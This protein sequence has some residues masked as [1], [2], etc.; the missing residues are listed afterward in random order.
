MKSLPSS[1]PSAFGPAHARTYAEGPARQV[2]GLDGLHRMTGQ[3][4]AERVPAGGRVLV[5]GAGGGLELEALAQ[6]HPGWR[7]DGVDPSAAML[8]GARQRTTAFADRITLHH[9]YVEAAPGGPF[10]GA[11]CL[12]T[13]HFVAAAQRCP[14][15]QQLHRRLARGAP[16]VVA[17]LSIPD[18]APG[19]WL[20]RHLRFGGTDEAQL[21]A[22]RQTMLD[23][24]SILSP[25]RDE[26]LLGEAG[27][28]DV[29]LFYAGLSLRGWVAYA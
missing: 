28:G 9:G 14:T 3:L 22:A 15:L 29:S 21:P 27:F 5:L 24:L 8:E 17:H 25:A 10:D 4:L 2:P 18:H 6:A 1:P 26:A 11:V 20:D 12:L 19:L 7:F 13:L 16:L 23:R